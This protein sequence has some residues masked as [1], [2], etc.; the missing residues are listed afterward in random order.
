MIQVLM[1]CIGTVVGQVICPNEEKYQPCTCSYIKGKYSITC[2][3]IYSQDLVKV[4][5][6]TDNQGNL[7]TTHL[8]L[9][10]SKTESGPF[11]GEYI[12]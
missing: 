6:S 2:E 1:I 7:E 11:V 8:D 10:T 9:N 12:Q 5:N 3:R 4:V